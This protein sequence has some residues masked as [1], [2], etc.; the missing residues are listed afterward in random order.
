ME[1]KAV[2]KER[3]FWTRARHAAR[4]IPVEVRTDPL[5]EGRRASVTLCACSGKNRISTS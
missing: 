5:T 3:S 2:R 4:S 1:F